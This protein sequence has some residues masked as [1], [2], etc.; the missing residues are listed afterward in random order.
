MKL[1]P[2]NR[3]YSAKVDDDDF[4]RFG[5]MSW[6]IFKAR[7]N[8]GFYAA[9]TGPRPRMQK[10]LL[11]RLVMGNPIGMQVDHF[12]HDKLDCQKHNL[13][14]CTPTQNG[15]NRKGPTAVSKT[16]FR[17]VSLFR[18]GK[19]T[20]KIVVNGKPVNLGYFFKKEDAANAYALAN[21]KYFGEFKG[22][23]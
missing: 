21:N 13:R 10:I 15:Q 8:D 9:H 3:G 1:I 16:G 20:A 14:V 18:N 12:N 4:D 19:Y 6:H 23:L 7:S 2:L 11:H 22:N 17:G 5:K